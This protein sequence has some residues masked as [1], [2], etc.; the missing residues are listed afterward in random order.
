MPAEVSLAGIGGPVRIGSEYTD[1]RTLRTVA[2]GFPGDRSER[3]LDAVG[4][5]MRLDL[6]TMGAPTLSATETEGRLGDCNCGGAHVALT[7]L[8]PHV[9][10]DAG[11]SAN[12]T[13]K[14]PRPG[15]HTTSLGRAGAGDPPFNYTI[16]IL[17][18]L[19]FFDG[20]RGIPEE[21]AQYQHRYLAES[22][23]QSYQQA[24][25]CWLCWCEQSSQDPCGHSIGLLCQFLIATFEE[26][27][28]SAS[29]LSSLHAAIGN[30]WGDF[31]VQDNGLPVKVDLSTNPQLQH[32]LKSC[33]KIAFV[34]NPTAVTKA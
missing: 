29:S 2:G 20:L 3:V 5:G 18:A 30:T 31:V 28:V 16:G 13:R 24:W 33:K 8:V 25:C 9:D 32:V 15:A 34:R 14:S 12:F 26:G 17:E 6:S 19:Q 10:P 11:G 1:T 4:R 27:N 21:A 22:T 7:G 23:E